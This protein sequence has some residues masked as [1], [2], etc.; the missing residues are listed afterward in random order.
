MIK[1]ISDINSIERGHDQEEVARALENQKIQKEI[2]A[3][4]EALDQLRKDLEDKGTAIVELRDLEERRVVLRRNLDASK[5]RS[6]EDTD[7]LLQRRIEALLAQIESLKKER[8][9]LDSK[10]QELTKQLEE[11]KIALDA[12]VPPVVVQPRG[13]GSS[14]VNLWFIECEASG[15][16]IRKS[17]GSRVSVSKESIMTEPA[18]AEFFN[19]A[20]ADRKAIILFLIRTDGND[21]F[22]RAAGWAEH[23]FGLRTAK[24]PI[25]NKGEID[26]SHF[27]R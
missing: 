15:L 10:I 5:A 21:T 24:L 4:K 23:Q 16:V 1:I 20:K 11:L 19:A 18:L 2:V 12:T 22:N 17:D 9:E 25:P 13:S 26:L 3:K 7:A 8:P 14:D 6:S 27:N